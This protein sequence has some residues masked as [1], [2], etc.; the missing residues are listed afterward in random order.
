MNTYYDM[1]KKDVED[2]NHYLDTT[3]FSEQLLFDSYLKSQEEFT[4]EKI[5][6]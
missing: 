1:L 2:I 4:T 6:E 5:A 3:S